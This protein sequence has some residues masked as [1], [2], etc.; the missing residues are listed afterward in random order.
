MT[1][2]MMSQCHIFTMIKSMVPRVFITINKYEI[3]VF[4][5]KINALIF[6]NKDHKRTEINKMFVNTFLPRFQ[7]KTVFLSQRDKRM[8]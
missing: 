3:N 8:S 7:A 5:F 4:H 2:V 1:Y 6:Q